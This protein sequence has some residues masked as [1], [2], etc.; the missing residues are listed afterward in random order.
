MEE[1]AVHGEAAVAIE[2]TCPLGSVRQAGE[3][4][5]AGGGAE[6]QAEGTGEGGGVH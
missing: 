3:D 5:R 4:G 1:G 6:P 2:V